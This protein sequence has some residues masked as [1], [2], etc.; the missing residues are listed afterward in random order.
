MAIDIKG[1]MNLQLFNL[2][3]NHWDD[4]IA[5]IRNNGKKE[6]AFPYLIHVPSSYSNADIRIMICG[7]ETYGWGNEYDG[8]DAVTVKEIRDIYHG[9]VN[10]G[11]G[12]NS[13]FWNFQKRIINHFP[14]IGFIRNN[15]VKIGKR[16]SPG[17]D[18]YIDSLTDKYFRVF[19]TEVEILQPHL[20]IFLTGNGKYDVKIRTNLG[21]FSVKSLSEKFLFEQLR[22]EDETLSLIHI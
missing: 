18:D 19:R 8:K 16:H 6:A 9:F 22:F 14:N 17:C 13:P 20:I 11:N 12:Y 7:Q 2:Y 5:K 10:I 1:Y 21:P 15:I 4:Y 3:Q